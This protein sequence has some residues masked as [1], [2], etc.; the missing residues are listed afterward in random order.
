MVSISFL[1][2]G[3]MAEAIVK[4]LLEAKAAKP[5]DI[6]VSDMSEDRLN[7]MKD[8]YKVS[9]AESNKQ[10][11]KNSEVVF[12]SVK[13]QDMYSLLQEIKGVSTK[14]KL[15]ISIAAGIRISAI[16]SVI[17]G[18]VVRVMPNLPCL[19]QEMAGAYA[20]GN[21]AKKEDSKT[22]ELLLGSCGLCINVEEKHLDAVTAL[23][24]S[25][26]AYAAYIINALAEAG[27]S[28][29]L[30]RET[31]RM[32][33]VQT[34]FGTAKY[35]LNKGVSPDELI[36]LVKSPKGTTVEGMKVIEKSEIKDVL[37][38]A[39]EAAAKRSRELGENG[40]C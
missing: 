13:P 21:S 5:S 14:D 6:T 8:K 39:V 7:I 33:S 27:E 16:E 1:G 3:K 22:V 25:G 20:T 23:S 18:R 38:R 28:Q 34:I 29:G 35:I 17:A 4:G 12:L 30:D 40:K 11:V 2:S 10:A 24:G 19:V 15:F 31:A 9:V 37:L 32:L 26:P 36:S